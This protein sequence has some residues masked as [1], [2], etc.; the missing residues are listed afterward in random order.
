L[1]EVAGRT[2]DNGDRRTAKEMVVLAMKQEDAVDALDKLLPQV[3]EPTDEVPSRDDED[4]LS[5]SQLS[6]IMALARDLQDRKKFKIAQQIL[7]KVEKI[8]EGRKR[9]K[10]KEP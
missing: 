7:S 5:E 9:K 3:P 2:L 6:R 8:E 4:N 10:R 1:L